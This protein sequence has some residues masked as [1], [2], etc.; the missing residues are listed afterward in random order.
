VADEV[1][2]ICGGRAVCD[3]VGVAETT[4]WYLMSRIVSLKISEFQINDMDTDCAQVIVIV[5]KRF[6]PRIDYI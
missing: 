6:D 5:R 4:L 1:L 2:H 3:N